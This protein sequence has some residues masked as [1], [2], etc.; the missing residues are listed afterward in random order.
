MT[1]TQTQPVAPGARDEILTAQPLEQ[2]RVVKRHT[3]A[4]ATL[5]ICGEDGAGLI[6]PEG[7]LARRLAKGDFGGIKIARRWFMTD[8]DI[9]AALSA[10]RNDP[11]PKPAP[12]PEQ[13]V[14]LSER[15]ARRLIRSA[16]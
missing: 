11:K 10:L 14:G 1:P 8:A 4:Q 15:A 12:E 5:I 7:W 3:L 6:D 9:D 16:S 2:G 13:P